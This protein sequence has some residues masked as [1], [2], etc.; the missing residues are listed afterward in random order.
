MKSC[1]LYSF[2]KE[3]DVKDKGKQMQN[4]LVIFFPYKTHI[5]IELQLRDYFH[6]NTL[7]DQLIIICLEF[8]KDS[9]ENLFKQD[10]SIY[11]YI[12]KFEFDENHYNICLIAL[13]HF[14]EFTSVIGTCPSEN[15]LDEIYNRGLLKIF[16]NNGGLIVSQTANHFVFP[17]G[18]H[19]NRFLRTGNVLITGNEIFF[20]ASALIR[21][22]KRAKFETL[23]S[24]TSSI[25]SLAFAYI[26][27]LKELNPEFTESV[28]VESFGS[29]TMFEKLKFK[30]K[31]DTIF[32]VS[33]STSGSILKR[34]T[35]TEN[36]SN[37]IDLKNIAIIFGLNVEA[38]YNAQVLCDLSLDEKNKDSLDPIKSYNL[39]KGE[40]CAFCAEGSKALKVEGDVFLLEKPI[41]SSY[42]VK[43]TDLPTYMKNFASY[44]KKENKDAEPIIRCYHK[45]K[46]F[47]DKK[48]EI[49]IDLFKVFDEW[50]KKED[51][52]HP[53]AAIF[54]KLEKYILQNIPASLKYI[55][56]LPDEG[57][58]RLA[59]IIMQ[60][61]NEHGFTFKQDQILQIASEELKTK[62]DKEQK[63]SIAIVSSSIVTGRNLLYLSRVLRDYEKTYQR[64]FFTF[65]NRTSNSEHFEFL[66]S[67]LSLGE[68]GK[69]THKIF[70]VEKIHCSAEA[71]HTPWHIEE[72][73]IKQFEEFFEQ[74]EDFI[75]I[76]KF[77]NERLKELSGCG[78]N[79][80]LSNNLFLP[81]L[82]NKILKIRTGF[83]FAPFQSG[84]QH[85]NFIVRS[86][87]S[88]IYFI[89]ATIL[90]ELRN[91]NIF[92]QGEYVRNLID[93]GNFVRYND[94]IIQAC[95]LRAAKNA[96]LDYSLSE[97][98]SMK[99]K[100]V[101]GDMILH[102]NDDHAE[103]LN[104][105]LYAIAIRK[106]KMTPGNIEDCIELLRE[107]D[108]YK[109]GDSILKGL[110]KFID[111]KIIER[112]QV[113]DKFKKMT[114]L[115]VN[116]D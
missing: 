14:G 94:G 1:Y 8:N 54:L 32:L 58:V 21:Y 114:R 92:R 75:A 76:K 30:A 48:Y 115:V 71:Q 82:K 15:Y 28:L 42:L 74:F 98:D 59:E 61:L 49:Y 5:D 95:F 38:P 63:G 20:I 73:C 55:I 65:A 37:N 68:F 10:S 102:L 13:N 88:E 22:F 26:N 57:S 46:T 19:S 60:V 116:D 110:V 35:D 18:K 51:T 104:E 52:T 64:I 97:E 23:Y 108:Y 43:Q 67:N 111:E 7:P 4:H 33:S 93:P 17:S 81:T 109:K 101:L 96:E 40:I 112:Q 83:A 91:K 78:K 77:C 27:L 80:G 36:K 89:I 53:Y 86:K 62:I 31:R 29:Y 6:N 72:N 11:N 99:M 2:Y 84:T 107:Q 70:N 105:F 47:K 90:N 44:Y 25:N 79:K 50:S 34:M 9:I 45:E 24:D 87:Q 106:L 85:N 66:E 3:V 103:G 113:Q 56:V 100:S 16:I 12:P 41:V 69:G 39:K